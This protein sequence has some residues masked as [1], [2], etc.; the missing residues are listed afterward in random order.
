MSWYASNIH[1][2][3]DGWNSGDIIIDTQGIEFDVTIQG[4]GEQVPKE[5]GLKVTSSDNIVYSVRKTSAQEFHVTIVPAGYFD[6][7]SFTLSVTGANGTTS[8]RVTLHFPESNEI[9]VTDVSSSKSSTNPA[10][11]V[12][13]SETKTT[14]ADKVKTYTDHLEARISPSKMVKTY[15]V[16]DNKVKQTITNTQ[17]QT[18]KTAKHTERQPVLPHTREQ[19]ENMLGALGVSL[20]IAT[21]ILFIYHKVAK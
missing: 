11:N 3:H 2:N 12:A 13:K 14:V 16:L 8:K 21:L 20:A 9:G 1:I 4:W 6:T 17:R 7:D 19:S 10:Q 5:L 18:P 15:L